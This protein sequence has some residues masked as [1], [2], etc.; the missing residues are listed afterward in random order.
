MVPFQAL[1]MVGHTVHAVCPGKKAGEI[2]RTAIHDFEGDQTHSEKPGHNFK[3]NATFADVKPDSYD[4]LVIPGGR[5]TEYLRLNEDLLRLVRHFAEAGKPISAICHGLQ[6]LAAAGVLKGRKWLALNSKTLPWTPHSWTA[7]WSPPRRGPRIPHGWQSFW[8]SSERASRCE[9]RPLQDNSPDQPQCRAQRNHRLAGRTAEDQGEGARG[10]R[11][12]ERGFAPVPGRSTGNPPNG[13]HDR[14][15]DKPRKPSSSASTE[16]MK[17][18][19]A[20]SW[21]SPERTNKCP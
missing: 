13:D 12:G 9:A 5:S 2:V 20:R 1:L 4:A 21:A 11:A 10:G 7:T 17:R 19:F 14:A 8:K 18:C 15:R 3:L 16:S 6:I